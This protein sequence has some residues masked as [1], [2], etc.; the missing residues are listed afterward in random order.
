MAAGLIAPPSIRPPDVTA[1]ERGPQGP[2]SGGSRLADQLF[3]W[4]CLASGLLVLVVLGLAGVV[5]WPSEVMV[6]LGSAVAVVWLGGAV[7]VPGSGA[8]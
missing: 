3:S 5:S 8:H 4:V 1:G 7:A 6:R 2:L